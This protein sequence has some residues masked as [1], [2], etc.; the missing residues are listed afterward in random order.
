MDNSNNEN[1][2]NVSIK[3]SDSVTTSGEYEIVPEDIADLSEKTL[4]DDVVA[5]KM[6]HLTIDKDFDETDK[7]ILSPVSPIL[8][9]GSNGNMTDLEKNLTEVIH[10]LDTND[11]SSSQTQVEK[12]KNFLFLFSL[13]S[14]IL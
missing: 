12:G 7:K 14:L 1:T 13:L 3:S 5:N 4:K 9:I 6:K 8:N 2:D 10:E 11:S